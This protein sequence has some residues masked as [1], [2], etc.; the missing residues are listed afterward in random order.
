[1]SEDI[2]SE[3]AKYLDSGTI[4]YLID[5]IANKEMKNRRQVIEGL[6]IDRETLYHSVEAKQ[7]VIKEAF[8][9]LGPAVVVQALYGNIKSLFTNFIIDLLTFAIE[10]DGLADF[11]KEVLE[12]NERILENVRDFDRREIIRLIKEKVEKS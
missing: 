12:E 1:M 9:S 3:Y 7:K 8:K 4:N 11:T 10:K 6:G 5:L 2:L